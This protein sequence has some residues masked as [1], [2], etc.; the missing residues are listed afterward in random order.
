[1]HIGEHVAGLEVQQEEIDRE[2]ATKDAITCLQTRLVSATRKIVELES[3]S[4]SLDSYEHESEL[5]EIRGQLQHAM[6]RIKGL[7]K[8]ILNQGKDIDEAL[9]TIDNLCI[10]ISKLEAEITIKKDQILREQENLFVQKN[11]YDGVENAFELRRKD[12]ADTAQRAAELSKDLSI[13]EAREEAGKIVFDRMMTDKLVEIV[14][15]DK[16]LE[17]LR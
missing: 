13:L 17:T 12:Y 1:L 15:K 3:T 8:I 16:E 7:N 4:H 10:D 2:N 6:K 9:T 14:M 5:S 11:I